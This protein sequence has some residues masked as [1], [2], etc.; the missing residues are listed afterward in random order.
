[1]VTHGKDLRLANIHYAYAYAYI[2]NASHFSL[3]SIHYAYA[4]WFSVQL[5]VY[6]VS[7]VC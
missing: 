4:S 6:V 7:G 5:V 1:M 2:H 3:K